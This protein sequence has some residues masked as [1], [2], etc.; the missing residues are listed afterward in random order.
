ME[1]LKGYPFEELEKFLAEGEG[2]AGG[3]IMIGNTMYRIERLEE[4]GAGR[5]PAAE[6]AEDRMALQRP[7]KDRATVLQPNTDIIRRG[8]GER[9]ISSA[10]KLILES[11]AGKMRR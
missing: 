1:E 2:T 10:Q 11:T 4:E 8:T 7:D 3:R 6:K 5:K 9:P